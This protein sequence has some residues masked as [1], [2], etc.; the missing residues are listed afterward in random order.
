MPCLWVSLHTL[1]G[2]ILF[3]C[4]THTST[5]RS[6]CSC[7]RSQSKGRTSQWSGD[8]AMLQ[9]LYSSPPTYSHNANNTQSIQP[10]AHR[11]GSTSSHVPEKLQ[12]LPPK[13]SSCVHPCGQ[14]VFPL[15]LII[16]SPP[17]IDQVHRAGK[18]RY[19]V[20]LTHKMFPLEYSMEISVIRSLE[21]GLYEQACLS[22]V[23]YPLRVLR[24]FI[25]KSKI[26]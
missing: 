23:N 24:D 11:S 12:K 3:K 1:P 7:S 26:Q 14:L 8:V 21:C 19:L 2:W 17:E 9:S 13:Q 10:H 18:L 5:A 15:L 6:V 25:V 22:E 20:S 16:F 4:H